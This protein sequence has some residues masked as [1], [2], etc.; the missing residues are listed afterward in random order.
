VANTEYQYDIALSFA[1]EDRNHAEAIAELLVSRNLK[2]FYDRYEQV[3]LWGKDLYQHLQSVYRD[4]ARYCVIFA[5]RHY[6]EKLWTK[7][8]LRQAQARAF[9]ESREYIL[10][11]RLDDTDIPGV[12]HTVGYIDL[13]TNEIE[14]IAHLICRKVWGDDQAFDRLSW[15]GEM[16]EFNGTQVAS[17]WPRRIEE[18]QKL[19]TYPIVSEVK[20]IPYGSEAAAR[21]WAE[22][23]DTP[24]HDCAAI[25]GQYHVPSCDMEQCPNCGGQLISC[26]CNI[27]WDEEVS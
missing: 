20:R 21:R 17:Y 7:H 2:V 6:A 13:R 14:D 8:E 23:A 11:L 5:S 12:N 9:E 26:G 10:P 19:A 16:V 15:N 18:A 25:K 4:K 1:G 24:C 3:E 27:L 22:F